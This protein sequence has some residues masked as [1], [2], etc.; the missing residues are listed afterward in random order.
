M[1][2]QALADFWKVHKTFINKIKRKKRKITYKM[3][4][5]LNQFDKSLTVLEWREVNFRTFEKA[6]ES[7]INIINERV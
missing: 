7:I 1:T 3:A 4:E 5:V 6:T 2:Q